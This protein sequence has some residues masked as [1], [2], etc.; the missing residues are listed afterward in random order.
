MRIHEVV[1]AINR[2]L[3]RGMAQYG[4][5]VRVVLCCARHM[6]IWSWQIVELCRTYLAASDVPLELNGLVVG[7]G[8][9]GSDE[10]NH[11]NK[12][13]TPM[14]HQARRYGNFSNGIILVRHLG[15][16]LPLS[17]Y[18]LKIQSSIASHITY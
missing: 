16:N 12:L 6:P 14:F 17:K 3:R 13:Q 5:K 10:I 15:I 1:E 11:P 7:I 9:I 18:A 2:G 8:L 4:N